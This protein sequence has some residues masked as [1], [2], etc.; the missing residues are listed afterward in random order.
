MQNAQ[1][2]IRAGHIQERVSLPGLV[3]LDY[4]NLRGGR[5]IRR[6]ESLVE[7]GEEDGSPLLNLDFSL[8]VARSHQESEL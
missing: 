8:T 6:P 3:R 2:P 4:R 5:V 1:R 7:P